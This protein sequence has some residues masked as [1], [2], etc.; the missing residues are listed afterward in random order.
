M[1]QI[2]RKVKK[3]KMAFQ[4]SNHNY[5]INVL[6]SAMHRKK[7]NLN[8]FEYNATRTL[9]LLHYILYI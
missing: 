2:I 4:V 8:F 9:V 3:E 6:Q 7:I 1:K 5:F